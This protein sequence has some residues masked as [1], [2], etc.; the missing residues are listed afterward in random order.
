MEHSPARSPRLIGSSLGRIAAPNCDNTSHVHRPHPLSRG[1]PA[2]TVIL[3]KRLLPKTNVITLAEL[4][5]GFGSK[6]GELTTAVFV[7]DAGTG[8]IEIRT[9]KLTVAEAPLAMF[10]KLH[11]TVPP[12][13][14]G[15][16]VQEAPPE[17]IDRNIDCAGIGS[18]TVTAD[19]WNGPWFVTVTV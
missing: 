10:P 19:A 1:V 2:Q 9:V 12:C 18:T 13:A 6:L 15:G 14:G 16:A 3:Y 8:G 5:A 7:T 11:V 17:F 4:L